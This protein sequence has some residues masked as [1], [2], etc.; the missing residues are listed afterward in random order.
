MCVYSA[1]SNACLELRAKHR[2]PMEKKLDVY[3]IEKQW[4]AALQIRIT[5]VY[6][7]YCLV[8]VT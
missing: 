3:I 7:V 8:K 1:K 4:K 2:G 6:F 5:I